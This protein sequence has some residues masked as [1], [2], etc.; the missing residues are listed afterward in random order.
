MIKF[1][2]F[3]LCALICAPSGVWA[4]R[5]TDFYMAAQ[6]LAAARNGNTRLVQN[7]INSGAN[8]NFVDSTGLSVVCTA[9]MNN[10]MRAVQV[11]QMY[12]ADAS[13]CDRQIKNYQAR[14]NPEPESGL[15][16]GLSSTHKLV[17]GTIGVAGVVGGLLWATDAFDGTNHNGSSSSSGNHG[18][19]SGGSSSDTVTAAF[20]VP[21]SP[22][23]LN[24]NGTINKDALVNADTWVTEE[25]RT[26]FDYIK[27]SDMQNY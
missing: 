5:S 22:A 3:L 16:S 10:D 25:G 13:N 23:Y 8:V 18:S 4:A 14:T 17:L 11:L 21:Y 15:F 12:G 2:R 24:T 6:L 1:N 20:T 9:V 26:D 7:L 19:G 27:N